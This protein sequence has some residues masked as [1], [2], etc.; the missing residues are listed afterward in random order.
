MTS[1]YKQ[2]NGKTEENKR[3]TCNTWRFRIKKGQKRKK[4]QFSFKKV[5][6]IHIY[7]LYIIL[8][9]ILKKVNQNA[10]GMQKKSKIKKRKINELIN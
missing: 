7:L 6:R 2:V 4:T 1:Y 10:T 3:D 5:F 8:N 9:I